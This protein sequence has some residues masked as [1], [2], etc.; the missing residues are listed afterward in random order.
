MS[1]KDLT[2]GLH[3][4]HGKTTTGTANAANV[5]IAY[6]KNIHALPLVS[7]GRVAPSEILL[8]LI[9]N[10]EKVKPVAP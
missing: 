10:A 9:A 4:T 1:T 6:Q 7:L 2:R 5:M 3:S 8:R